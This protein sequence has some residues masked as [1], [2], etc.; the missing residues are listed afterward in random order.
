MISFQNNMLSI[1]KNKR[2]KQ[3]SED[4]TLTMTNRSDNDKLFCRFGLIICFFV[5]SLLQGCIVDKSFIDSRI[6]D[7]W[8]LAGKIGI[9]Y[10]NNRCQK[11]YCPPRSEQGNLKWQQRKTAYHFE[12]SDPFGRTVMTITGDEQQLLA[13]APGQAPIHSTPSEFMSLLVGD[14]KQKMLLSNLSPQDLRY[15]VTGRP[16]PKVPHEKQGESDFI[17]KGFTINTRQWRKTAAG[18][19]PALVIVYKGDFKLRVVIREWQKLDP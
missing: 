3:R 2:A 12:V 9:A 11:D 17:Q 7:T 8:G 13:K 4:V 18:N 15:W 10:P 14:N 5:V 1:E 19:M 6:V 16:V